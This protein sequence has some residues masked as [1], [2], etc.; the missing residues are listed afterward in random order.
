MNFIPLRTPEA[1]FKFHVCMAVVWLV[2][3]IVVPF[4][5]WES[6]GVLAIIEVSLYANFST[7]LGALDSSKASEQTE[8]SVL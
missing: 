4:L 2:S 7:E 1:R 3:M 5:H 6:V 8:D